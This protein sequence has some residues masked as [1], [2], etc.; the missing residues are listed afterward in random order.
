MN[1]TVTFSMWSFIKQ[2]SLL[3]IITANKEPIKS[4][5]VRK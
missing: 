3:L 4:F 5:V 1:I 2:D